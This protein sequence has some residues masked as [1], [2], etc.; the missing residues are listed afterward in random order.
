MTLRSIALGCL[1][2]AV[3]ACKP[4]TPAEPATAAAP[5]NV[6]ADTAAA[7]NPLPSPE[8]EVKASM[9]KFLKA[10]SFHAVMTMEGARG[11][12]NEMDFVAPDRYRMKM[13]VGT[14]VIIGDTMY[15]QADGR[16]MKVPLPKGTLSQWRDP[17]KIEEN[18]AGLS[19]EALGSDSVEGQAAKKYLVRNTQ[20][21]P[22]QPGPNEF[23]FWIADDGLPLQLLHQGQAQGKPY[24]MTLRYSRFD[25][26]TIT[27]D[28]PQ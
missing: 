27:I 1:V 11:M 8:D 14:Q 6:V 9:D 19:V 13:P 17:L 16:S 7:L 26:P 5:A 2:L 4:S 12:T 3:A 23:T 25:D 28:A 15:M 18:K 10:K 20:P 24:S 21:E 22:G